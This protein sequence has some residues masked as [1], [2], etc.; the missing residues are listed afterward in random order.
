MEK[1]LRWALKATS[2]LASLIF[3]CVGTAV[4]VYGGYE[5][6]VALKSML[7][8]MGTEEKVVSEVLK[9]SDLV[10][11]GI[12]LQLLGVGLFELFIRPIP[13]LPDWLNIDSFDK[14]K[15]LLVK[16]AILVIAIS[17]VGKAVTWDGKE[18]IMY[19]GIGIGAIIAALS[20]FIRVK[21]ESG[22]T[23]GGSKKSE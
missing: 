8:G 14:L 12:V 6:F 16:A 4:L 2:F 20:Y 5:S 11:L 19:Y 23:G 21:S 22:D 18:N 10:F 7:P 13:S 1:F 15:G 9:A 3:V 17:F